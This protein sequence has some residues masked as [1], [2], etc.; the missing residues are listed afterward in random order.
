MK[1]K[2]LVLL[3]TI[4]LALA[5]SAN[6]PGNAPA[7]ASAREPKTE[8]EKAIYAL[9]VGMSRQIVPFHLTEAEMEILM[10]GLSDGATNR[11]RKVDVEAYRERIAQIADARN[12]AV[13]GE[14][15]EAGA[16]YA[17]KAA[18]E[19]GARK[20]PTGLVMTTIEEGTGKSPM[21][22]DTVKVRYK[23]TLI[24][25]TAFDSTLG[26]AE[27]ATLAMGRVIPCWAQALQ[28]MKEGGKARIVCPSDLAYAD[29]GLLP[30]IMPG[31][32]LVFDVELIEVKR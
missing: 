30:R 3:C 29:T 12:T 6:A 14:A 20:L 32:T 18:A 21:L 23:G 27:P 24:D 17:L 10:A 2:I 4:S 16:A 1:K 9:G 25:G 13:A 28:L 22:A 15:K 19:K 5:C 26:E 8:D 31:A 11:A 7:S